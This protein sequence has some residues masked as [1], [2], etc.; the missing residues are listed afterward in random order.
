AGQVRARQLEAFGDL[1]LVLVH[2]RR[3][4]LRPAGLQFFDRVLGEVLFVLARCVVVGRHLGVTLR[5]FYSSWWWGDIP[6]GRYPGKRPR[7]AFVPA[8]TGLCTT[9]RTGANGFVR[10]VDLGDRPHTS[11]DRFGVTGTQQIGEFADQAGR[12]GQ[13]HLAP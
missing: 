4:L 7:A 13:R 11:S 6:G 5:F 10:R 12:A 9:G 3:A 2:R 1:G 8:D